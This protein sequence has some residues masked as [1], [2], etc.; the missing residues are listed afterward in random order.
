MKRVAAIAVWMV[1]VLGLAPPVLAQGDDPLSVVINPA[2]V[3]TRLGDTIE[4]EVVV[5]NQTAGPISDVA[6]HL[7]ITDPSTEGSVDPED[8]TATLTQP[9]GTVEP[10]QSVTLQWSL[11][12]ISGGRFTAYA[13]ALHPASPDVAASNAATITVAEQRALNPEGVLPIAIGGPVLIG[14]LLVLRWRARRTAA[15]A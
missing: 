13:V 1:V 7:D 10:G 6:V 3:D 8:W 12:P 14:S 4:V 15:A 11:Q 5:T 2:G 9:A